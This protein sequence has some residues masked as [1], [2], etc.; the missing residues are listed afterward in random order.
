[1]ADDASWQLLERGADL[2]GSPSSL[3]T[4]T[5]GFD[6]WVSVP[7]A[8]NGD[9]IVARFQLTQGLWSKLQSILFKPPG[10]LIHFEYAGRN[11]SWRFVAA[12]APDLHV[13]QAA[14]TLGYSSAFVPITPSRLMFSIE[15]GAQ[16]EVGVRVL[17]YGIHEAAVAN[18]NGQHLGIVTSSDQAA[19]RLGTSSEPAEAFWPSIAHLLR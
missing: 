10:V 11:Q 15:G 18:D 6:H 7:T 8:P 3:G 13:I 14:S 1:M 12:T 16:S 2:C 19:P 9:A 4:V 5:T 17:F